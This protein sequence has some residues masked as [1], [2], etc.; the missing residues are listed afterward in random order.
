M[1][2]TNYALNQVS[3]R[4]ERST[5]SQLVA[6]YVDV[7]D[8]SAT[9]QGR[10]HQVIYGRRGTGKT[11]V[12]AILASAASE[13]GDLVVQCDLRTLG[14]TGGIYSD[15]T[16]PLA[17]RA[18]RLL[19]DLLWEFHDGILGR[20]IDNE[21]LDLGL[22]QNRLDQFA[23]SISEVRVVGPTTETTAGTLT[24]GAS[25]HSGLSADL[26][27]QGGIG[28]TIGGAESFGHSR[29][30]STTVTGD[31]RHRVHFGSVA[32]NI[33]NLSEATG[34]RRIWLLLDE[35]SEV[36]LDLQPYLSDL[37]RRTVF[38]VSGVTVK[39][40]AIEQR[41]NFRL[42]LN[43][44]SYLGIEI[45]A[46]GAPSLTLDD[47][48]VFDNDSQA[49]TSFVR[50]LLWRH[51]VAAEAG[52]LASDMSEDGF[53]SEAF[54]QVNALQEL[55][56]AAEGVPRDAINIAALAAR[57]AGQDKISVVHVRL[58][59][60]QWYQQSK[61]SAIAARSMASALLHWIVERVI[62]GR[63]ARAFLLPTN[64]RN[65]L[66]EF[67]YDA[68]VLHVIKKSVSSNDTPGV[69]YNVFSIDY[70][71][72]VDLISTGNAPSGLFEIEEEGGEVHYVDVPNTDYRSI[73]RA[74]LDIEEFQRSQ[75]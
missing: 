60:R 13:T 53:T 6:S 61:E 45:G 63:R 40:A 58:A 12:L 69:R 30:R 55:A 1:R 39:I 17:E 52:T 37:L 70:G 66:V 67:L 27:P 22:I 56:R 25:N 18:T 29:S 16:L 32:R 4:A 43:D 64:L 73:R 14:S 31:I 51:A 65:D 20:A 48:M 46:D 50:K 68:R 34:G 35:W 36:P 33:G 21:E 24:S 9:V 71:C 47:Y 49:A 42:M 11:H 44:G 62:R 23:G 15:T 54:T 3:R 8:L 59:A 57:S 5:Q 7:G 19:S 72:Y 75:A 74:I 41:T 26:S 2:P 38:P 10:D 28:L